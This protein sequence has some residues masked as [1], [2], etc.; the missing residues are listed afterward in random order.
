M[1]YARVVAEFRRTV[2]AVQAETFGV[3]QELMAMWSRGERLGPDQV[4][5]R[6][7]GANYGQNRTADSDR[8]P[9]MLEASGGSRRGGGGG[10]AGGSIVAV[11]PIVGIISNRACM[12]SDISAGGGTSV[13]RLTSQFRAAL[14]QPSVKAIVLDVDS[15]GGGVSGVFELANEIA[16]ARGRKKIIAVCNTQAASAAYA[17]AAAASEVV[18]PPSGF[19]GSIGV[20]SAV[21][22]H[23]KELEKQGVKIEFVSAGKYKTEGMPTQP[24]S[25][26][27]RA[28]L[29]SQVDD[30]YQIFVRAIANFRGD[31]QAN[32]REGYGQGRV[33]TAVRAVRA[34]LADRV[35]TLD[36]VLEQLGVY[37][38]RIPSGSTR[39]LVAGGEDHADALARRRWEL[40]LAAGTTQSGL[41]KDDSGPRRLSLRQAQLILEK[42]RLEL[43]TGRKGRAAAAGGIDP[44]YRLALARRRAA[45]E[46]MI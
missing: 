11:I 41:D 8:A 3:M 42:E 9:T 43:G 23:S 28:Y 37:R 40:A 15:P 27:A 26:D 35:A 10:S 39:M 19:A 14:A 13:E 45:L 20:F 46:Q 24:L 2:W 22:D 1:S 36:E 30:F 5:S 31:S 25:D 17:L 44:D 7:A 34:N 18:I 38:A 16:A 4:A 21:E 33:V 29:Q 32:V 6:I 12:F